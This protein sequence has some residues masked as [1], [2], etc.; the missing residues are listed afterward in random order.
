[1]T[2]RKAVHDISKFLVLSPLV[3]PTRPS[4]S[5]R[6]EVSSDSQLSAQNGMQVGDLALLVLVKQFS[7]CGA[8][9][10]KNCVPSKRTMN[11]FLGCQP[12]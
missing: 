9:T 11:P 1:M 4:R 2:V 7:Q 10:E 12:R 8:A 5:G 3:L 6:L